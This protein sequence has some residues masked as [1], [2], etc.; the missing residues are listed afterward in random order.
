[1]PSV[2]GQSLRSWRRLVRGTS[3]DRCLARL[4]CGFVDVKLP[5]ATEPLQSGS[6][7]VGSHWAKGHDQ[8]LT[9]LLHSGTVE[10]V[11]LQR[12]VA[13]VCRGQRR[14]SLHSASPRPG[15]AP[16]RALPLPDPPLRHRYG[17]AHA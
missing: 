10:L 1:V 6:V 15:H 5:V 16:Y 14:G 3:A 9:R 13:Q 12:A 11:Q 4:G 7:T 2:R 8:L 17:R